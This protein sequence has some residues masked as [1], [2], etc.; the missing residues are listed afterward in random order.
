MSVSFYATLYAS[1][2]NYIIQAMK[3]LLQPALSVVRQ[4]LLE[5]RRYKSVQDVAS[6]SLRSLLIYQAR[7]EKLIVSSVLNIDT[8]QQ[9]LLG[10]NV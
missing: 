3:F 10:M 2:E 6:I 8:S 7:Y 4:G 1:H 9:A 5:R